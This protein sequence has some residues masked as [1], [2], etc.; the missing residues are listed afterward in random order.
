MERK[1]KITVIGNDEQYKSQTEQKQN[2]L[3]TIE[4]KIILVLFCFVS[5]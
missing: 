1:T 2:K 3:F 4:R 5:F